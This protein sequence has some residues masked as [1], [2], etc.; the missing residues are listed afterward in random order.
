MTDPTWV[1]WRVTNRTYS[2][3]HRSRETGWTLCGRETG[4]QQLSQRETPPSPADECRACRWRD[5]KESE[6][7]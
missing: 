6:N 7:P 4:N 2:L 1:A 5:L 3:W